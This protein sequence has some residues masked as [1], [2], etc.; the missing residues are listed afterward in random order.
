MRFDLIAFTNHAW[1]DCCFTDQR[2]TS[3]GP[4]KSS[5]VT[6]GRRPHHFVQVFANVYSPLSFLFFELLHDLY[7][8]TVSL[9]RG[10]SEDIATYINDY[11]EYE[12]DPFWYDRTVQT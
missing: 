11:G 12:T 5:T 3:D 10:C 1:S 6:Q 7:I 2:Q 4:L 9:Q 8:N